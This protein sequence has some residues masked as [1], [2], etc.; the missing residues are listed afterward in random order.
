M[1]LDAIDEYGDGQDPICFHRLDQLR[2]VGLLR[3]DVL[4]VQQHAYPGGITALTQGPVLLVPRHVL[5]GRPIIPIML[6]MQAPC[7]H[8]EMSGMGQVSTP[9]C[10]DDRPYSG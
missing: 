5:P 7:R 1:S 8:T 9:I 6:W 3:D 2:N 10:W 4:A